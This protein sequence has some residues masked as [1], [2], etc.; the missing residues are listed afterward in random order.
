MPTLNVAGIFIYAYHPKMIGRAGNSAL[1]KRHT[2]LQDN[3]LDT[4]KADSTNFP[5]EF[6]NLDVRKEAEATLSLLHAPTTITTV[7]FWNHYV[8]HA[9]RSAFAAMVKKPMQ[10]PLELAKRILIDAGRDPLSHLRVMQSEVSFPCR[11]PPLVLSLTLFWPG[12]K[13]RRLPA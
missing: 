5:P 6:E 7:Q 8:D 4:I 9:M 12:L 2:G 10:K 13:T 1:W 11:H 3:P